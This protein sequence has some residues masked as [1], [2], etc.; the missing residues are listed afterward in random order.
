[1]P[2]KI[3]RCIF[4]FSALLGTFRVFSDTFP[5]YSALMVSDPPVIDGILDEECWKNAEKTA[6][7]VAIGGKPAKTSTTG[8]LCWDEKI[9]YIAFVCEEPEMDVIE[10]RIKTGQIKDFD[11]SIEVFIDSNY[12][13]SSYIQL[14]LGITGM[15]ESRNGAELAPEIQEGWSAAIRRYADRWT[16]EMGVPFRLL[17]GIPPGPDVIW[18]L[19]LNGSRGVDLETDGLFWSGWTCWSDTKG[20]FAAPGRF[21]R[22]IF[23]DYSLWLRYRYTVLTGNLIQEVAD[24]LMRYPL[25]GRPFMQE[26]CAI[27]RMWTDFLMKLA[28]AGSN[29]SVTH[30]VLS[31]AGDRV[32]AAYEDFLSRMRLAVIETEFH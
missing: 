19:N 8:M 18:G 30:D 29:P 32:V 12:D 14:R 28:D 4:I 16:V 11:Q 15:R 6:P 23:A 22:L 17:G 26:L 1:M 20:P 24:M 31:S 13:R 21:G 2:V 25:A 10:N 7:F 3:L 27:D 5:M 9:L